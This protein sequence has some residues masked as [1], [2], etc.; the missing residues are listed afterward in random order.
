M[1]HPKHLLLL[2][3][4]FLRTASFAQDFKPLDNWLERE[5]PQ[6]GGRAVLVIWKDGKVVY[7]HTVNQASGR[8]K[9]VSNML[10]R[11]QGFDAGSSGFSAKTVLPIAS[12][13]KWLSAA[14]VMTFIDEGKLKLTDTVGKFLPALSRGGKGSITIAQCLS[15]TTGV[16]APPLR[17]NLQDMRDNNSMDDAIKDIAA[18]PLE[19][20]PGTVFHYSNVGLQI[21]GAVIEKLSGQDFETLFHNRI[22]QP[23]GMTSTNF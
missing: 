5:A 20:A 22:A 18:M 3:A 6:M 13:S 12:C 16:D 15:H 10:G 1:T 14:L 4:I 19:G 8:Q 23:L 21:A 17:E 9:M 2:L 11:R 7:Q